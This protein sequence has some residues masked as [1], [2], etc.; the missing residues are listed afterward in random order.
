MNGGLVQYCEPRKLVPKAPKHNFDSACAINPHARVKNNPAPS[1]EFLARYA[2]GHLPFTRY[3]SM[4][5][6]IAS[7]NSV[8]AS[9]YWQ[10]DNAKT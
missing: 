1:H 5:R 10:S 8:A 2:Y 6:M 3:A 7:L 4:W 9:A